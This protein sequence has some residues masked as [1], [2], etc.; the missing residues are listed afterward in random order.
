MGEDTKQE[1]YRK[2]EAFRPKIA[3]P[4][5]WKDLSGIEISSDDLFANA[6]NIREFNYVDEIEKL[7]EPTRFSTRLS[8]C[9]LADSG[10]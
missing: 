4:D 5:E 8:I 2:L 10:K 6:Q 7:G 9:C 3:Y 1:A